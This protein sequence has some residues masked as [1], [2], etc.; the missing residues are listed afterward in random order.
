MPRVS[1][2]ISSA[3]RLVLLLASG[4][5]GLSQMTAGA[6]GSPNAASLPTT[7]LWQ[8]HQY[9]FRYMGF[10]TT[11]SCDGLSNKLQRLLQIMGARSDFKVQ[12]RCSNNSGGPDRFA[13]AHLDFSSLRAAA[14]SPQTIP[15]LWHHVR[16]SPHRD[17]DLGDGDCELVEQLRDSL[18]P[19]FSTRNLKSDVICAP[20][21]P[22]STYSLEFDVLVPADRVGGRGT[23]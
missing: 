14:A 11:Y 1:K 12:S 9:D 20:F 4:C 18:L 15:G 16:L 22:S 2:P 5:L 17:L 10:T 7:G 8:A 21:Q 23:R 13:A 6:D 19:F 3:A